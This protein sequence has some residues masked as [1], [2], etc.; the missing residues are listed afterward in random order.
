MTGT[1]AGRLFH[2][3]HRV[4]CLLT[5]ASTTLA[6]WARAGARLGKSVWIKKSALL[7]LSASGICLASNDINLSSVIPGR[8]NTRRRCVSALAVATTT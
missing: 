2:A 4:A 6:T 3:A 8:S 7:R 1:A 5:K